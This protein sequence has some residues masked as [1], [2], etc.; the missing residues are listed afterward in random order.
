[1]I[2]K[3]MIRIV[4]ASLV[5][6]LAAPFV[7]ESVAAAADFPSK[8]LRM[9]VPFRAGGSTDTTAR[10]LASALSNEIGKPVVVINKAGA[11]GAVGT[12]FL[13]D[14]APDGHT[15]MIGWVGNPLWDPLFSKNATYGRKDFRYVIAVS[16]FQSALVARSDAPFNNLKELIAHTKS[17]GNLKYTPQSPIGQVLINAIKAKEGLNWTAIPTKGGGEMVPLLLGGQLDFAFS[18]GIHNRYAG[19]MKVLTSLNA[20]RLI[21][22]PDVPTAIELGYNVAMPEYMVAMVPGKTPDNV[23]DIL[24]GALS[25]ALDS[26]SYVD[27]LTNK[28]KMGRTKLQGAELEKYLDNLTG[29]LQDIAK[30]VKK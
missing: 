5:A 2:S 15:L 6:I 22:N 18:G 8:P 23:V 10:V 4:G 26:K 28:M 29:Q 30:L 21:A 27:L 3:N 14:Q 17:K 11:G 19:K 9:I 12:A 16:I 25:K 1:M 13:K 20:T 24:K 7:A